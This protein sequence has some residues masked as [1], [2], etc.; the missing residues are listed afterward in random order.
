MPAALNDRQADNWRPPLGIADLAGG[1]WPQKARAAALALSS[2]DEDAETIGVQLLADSQGWC[3]KHAELIST[4]NLLKQLH[5]MS[6]APWGEYGRQ[7]KP[8]TP[9]QLAS[10]L[11]PFGI[12]SGTVRES[13][14]S[15]PKGYRRAQ[16]EEH[17]RDT[18][19]NPPQRHNPAN[20]PTFSDFP[21]ATTE[22]NV[23]DGNRAKS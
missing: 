1:D 9:R 21:S 10:L 13:E 19:L 8:I 2:V 12:A 15:T 11:R 3:S 4:E 16:F 5:A 23:A 7:R 22:S 14:T 17:G 6:E 20:P 18:S